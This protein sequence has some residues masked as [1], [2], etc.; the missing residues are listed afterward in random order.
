MFSFIELSKQFEQRFSVRHFPAEPAN[1]YNAA[2]Y[3]LTIGGKR[4]RPVCVLMGNELFDDINPDAWQVGM[5]V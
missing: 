1:L 3:I 5:A 4:I 2:Q